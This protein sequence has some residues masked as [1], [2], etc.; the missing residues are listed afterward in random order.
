MKDIKQ[1][2]KEGFDKLAE[3]YGAEGSPAAKVKKLYEQDFTETLCLIA[4]LEEIFPDAMTKDETGEIIFYKGVK[5]YHI[6][7]GALPEL[8]LRS[9]KPFGK[10]RTP[11][12]N[13]AKNMQLMLKDMAVE[14]SRE[15]TTERM[16][17]RLRQF[18]SGDRPVHRKGF[19]LEFTHSQLAKE[20]GNVILGEARRLKNG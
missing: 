18:S 7:I 6:D 13:R 17:E 20:F 15:K 11:K 16:L 4:G 5:T 9:R 12:G 3:F 1:E 2:I 19:S 14:I 8:Y 10:K